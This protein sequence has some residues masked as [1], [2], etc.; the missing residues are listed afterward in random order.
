MEAPCTTSFVDLP[1]E[2]QVGIF[3]LLPIKD[4]V[5]GRLVCSH[6]N[7]L[8]REPSIWKR[9]YIQLLPER[10]QEND[11]KL[12]SM[13]VVIAKI[14]DLKRFCGVGAKW[15]VARIDA[16][17]KLNRVGMMLDVTEAYAEAQKQLASHVVD[18]SDSP[19]LMRTLGAKHDAANFYACQLI[20]RLSYDFEKIIGLIPFAN[21]NDKRANRILTRTVWKAINQNQLDE[22][23][24]L[25]DKCRKFPFWAPCIV[26]LTRLLSEKEGEQE[27][28]EQFTSRFSNVANGSKKDEAYYYAY[29]GR[30]Q[31]TKAI[32]QELID[33]K[34]RSARDVMGLIDN[35]E[36][37]IQTQKQAKELELRYLRARSGLN[38]G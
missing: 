26:D 31:R 12:R 16:I 18:F 13:N 8:L 2:T 4:V 7:G 15:S 11:P 29:T 38:L 27:K 9:F 33:V 10:K 21:K 14:R 32:A 6:W 35:L 28:L 3:S 1:Q 22:V 5:M 24:N 19:R 37:S 30:L 36:V 25:L 17:V 23:M 20:K 34:D